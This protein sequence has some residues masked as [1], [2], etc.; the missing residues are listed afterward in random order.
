M[1]KTKTISIAGLLGRLDWIEI[2]DYAINKSILSTAW[3]KNPVKEWRNA[4]DSIYLAILNQL[5]Q[6]GIN[7]YKTKVE[8]SKK[9]KKKVEKPRKVECAVCGKLIDE[10]KAIFEPL[11]LEYFCSEECHESFFTSDITEWL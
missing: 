6:Q 10:D 8:I 4:G 5:R 1:S 2:L 11:L 9:L 3:N 7:P